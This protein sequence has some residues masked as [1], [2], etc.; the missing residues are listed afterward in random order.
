M[1]GFFY[2]GEMETL[3]M[4]SNLESFIFSFNSKS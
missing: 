2:L 3:D 4:R 1:A